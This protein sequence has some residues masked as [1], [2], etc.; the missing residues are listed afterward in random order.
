[1]VDD[2]DRYVELA[3]ALLRQYDYAT[4]CEMAGPCWSCRLREGCDL[5]HAHDWAETAQ[6]LAMNPDVD[7]VLLDVAFDI[8]EERLLLVKGGDRDRSRRLQGIEILRRLREGHRELPVVLMT[9]MEALQFEEAA[10][11]LAV[12]EFAVMAG[13]DAFDARALGLLIERVLSR[14]REAGGA[15][16]FLFGRTASMA[17]IATDTRN[18]A[19]TALPMLL[20]GE[21]GTGKSALA[22]RVIHPATGR[23]GP[24][25][26][27][28][29]GAIPETLMA[30][31]LFGAVPGA[32]SGATDRAGC[33][34]HARAGTLF[35]D[36]VGNLPLEVQRMLLVTLQNSEIKR[37]GE[38][39]A[40]RVDVKLV[41]ATN[42]DL[43][44][45]VQQ[46]RF[47]EDLYQRL[48]PAARITLPPLRERTQDIPR[49]VERFIQKTFATG[50][51]RA[52]LETYLEA[53]GLTGPPKA[54]LKVGASKKEPEEG[55]AFVMSGRTSNEL[56]AHPWPGNIRELELLAATASVFALSDALA[57]A[58]AGRAASEARTIPIPAKLV[59]DLLHATQPAAST[60]GGS[61]DR[62]LFV[63]IPPSPTLRD[64]TRNLET[65]IM[66]RLF[67]E[68]GG[69][70]QE[71][72][73][74]LLLG[75][76]KSNER[77]VRLRFNQLGLRVRD[78]AR[79]RKRRNSR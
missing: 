48:N 68:T 44:R 73:R 33:F 37:L 20:L 56:K 9:S 67:E 76:P 14:Q 42:I 34:E 64:L 69:D 12:D 52:L 32:F 38:N 28:D 25:V 71:M 47:R 74:R 36:E 35:L 63:K 49:L 40:K 3:H 72:A 21:P 55:V 30:A 57:A 23:Q 59:R 17:R 41:A 7:V 4:R 8:P 2:R 26:T 11:A 43:G 45:A 31:E 65:Q 78:L 22:E 15:E 1:V 62:G 60:A 39:S 27:V 24:F 66:T 54:R 70:F 46:G 29:L 19:R 61:G 53:A 77:R 10:E 79:N 18:L 13:A 50:A 5:T 16:G 6:A 58:E 75:D 51:N